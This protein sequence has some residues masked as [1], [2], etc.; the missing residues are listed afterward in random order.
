M[1]TWRCSLLICKYQYVILHWLHLNT[2]TFSII[3]WS[4]CTIIIAF[5]FAWIWG[6]NYHRMTENDHVLAISIIYHMNFVFMW[7]TAS[8]YIKSLSTHIMHS[9][10]TIQMINTHT[11]SIFES[12]KCKSLDHHGQDNINTLYTGQPSGF[13]HI[14]TRSSHY[15]IIYL[16]Q[17]FIFHHGQ[18]IRK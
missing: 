7:K 14:V 8:D 9:D 13:C 16:N 5:F 10:T 2:V 18:K 15:I 6:S 17:I 4:W 1:S 12:E 11:V 3:S